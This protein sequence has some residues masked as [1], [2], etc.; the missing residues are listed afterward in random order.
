VCTR[1]VISDCFYCKKQLPAAAAIAD[2]SGMRTPNASSASGYTLVEQSSAA[3]LGLI[4]AITE[5]A[6][7]TRSCPQDRRGK[8]S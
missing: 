7:M 3:G 6:P 1:K 8:G 2:V 5:N 4:S